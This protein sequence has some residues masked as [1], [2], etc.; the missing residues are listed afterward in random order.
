MVLLSMTPGRLLAPMIEPVGAEQATL[1]EEEV[2]HD[3]ASGTAGLRR[4]LLEAC[5]ALHWPTVL[6]RCCCSHDPPLEE[7]GSK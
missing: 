2:P 7:Q 5:S 3:A 6:V 1:T 4:E